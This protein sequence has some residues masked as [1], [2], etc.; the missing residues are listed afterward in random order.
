MRKHKKLRAL[1]AR[2]GIIEH[3]LA[4]DMAWCFLKTGRR[5]VIYPTE[6]HARAAA[7]KLN[8]LPRTHHPGAPYPCDRGPHWHLRSARPEDDVD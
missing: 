4:G 5:K 1:N 3:V 8:K 2:K 6:E 7:H